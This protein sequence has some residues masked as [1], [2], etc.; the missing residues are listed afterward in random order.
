MA[1]ESGANALGLLIGAAT[2]EQRQHGGHVRQ[3]A[4]IEAHL[5]RVEEGQDGA[6]ALPGDAG[7]QKQPDRA[8]QQEGDGPEPERWAQL[9]VIVIAMFGVEGHKA[10]SGVELLMQG[11]WGGGRLFARRDNESGGHAPHLCSA[12]LTPEDV[13]ASPCA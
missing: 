2:G 5:V 12:C 6:A 10:R 13:T 11:I 7:H 9:A 4:E 8:G 1:P 3:Q